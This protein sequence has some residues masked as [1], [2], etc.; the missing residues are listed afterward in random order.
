MPLISS[1]AMMRLARGRPR[2]ARLA[3]FPRSRHGRGALGDRRKE[4]LARRNA[5]PFHDPRPDLALLA[6]EC[7]K[8]LPR[9]G[10]YIEAQLGEALGDRGLRERRTEVGAQPGAEWLRRLRV[11]E[12]GVE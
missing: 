9:H 3:L 8:L 6:D 12:R 2:D 7:R 11:G 4:A 10:L 5:C 1:L